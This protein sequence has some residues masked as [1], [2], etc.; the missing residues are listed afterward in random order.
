[1]QFLAV[2]QR[3]AGDRDAAD[4]DRLHDHGGHLI[5]VFAQKLPESVCG[6]ELAGAVELQHL[7]LGCR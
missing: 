2:V 5:L 6:S 1:M 4:V 3:G 7:Q